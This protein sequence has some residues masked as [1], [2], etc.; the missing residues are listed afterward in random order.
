MK[1]IPAVAGSFY[2]AKKPEF[3]KMLGNFIKKVQEKENA[4]GVVSPHA[5]YIYSGA[6]T[7]EVFSRI[8]IPDEVIILCPN[9]TGYGK[10]FSLWPD[11]LWLTPLGEVKLSVELTNLI[12]NCYNLIEEDTEAHLREHSAEV[13]IPFLQYLKPM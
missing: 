5:G 3:E 8:Y 4:I 6:V 12:K 10:P 9:H 13:Q 11:G 2:P 1:R 7:G